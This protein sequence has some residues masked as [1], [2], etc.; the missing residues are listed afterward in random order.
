MLKYI[1]MQTPN[2]VSDSSGWK[3]ELVWMNPKIFPSFYLLVLDQSKWR[4]NTSSLVQWSKQGS[5]INM[6]FQESY[7]DILLF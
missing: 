6:G 1:L 7:A 5:F 3:A 4:A 2:S